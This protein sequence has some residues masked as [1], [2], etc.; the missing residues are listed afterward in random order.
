MIKTYIILK[1]GEKPPI[2]RTNDKLIE[3]YYLNKE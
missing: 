1:G 3:R 2:H